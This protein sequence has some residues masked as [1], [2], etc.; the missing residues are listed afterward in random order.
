MAL[1][2][3]HS[4]AL[5]GLQAPPVTVEA[6]VGNGLPAFHLVGLPDAEVRESRERVRAAILEAGLEFPQRRLTVNLAPADLPKASG[7][8]DLPIALGLLAASGQ[9]PLARLDD[10]EFVGELSLTGSIRSIRGALAMVRALRRLQGGR[11]LVVPAGNAAEAGLVADTPACAAATLVEVVAY[12]RGERSLAACAAPAWPPIAA[13]G[14]DLRDVK[15]Q[16]AAR[17]ALEIAAAGE[18]HLLMVG[19][20]GAGKSMLAQRIGSILPPLPVDEAIEAAAVA[21]LRGPLA[22]GRWQLRPVRAP[23]HSASAAAIVGGGSPPGPGEISLAHGGVLFLDELPEFQR[24]VLEALREPLEAG[25]ISLARAGSA[26]TLPARF[27]LLA[28]MNPCPCG[29]AG[30]PRCRCRAADVQRY[31]ARISGPL[32]ERIDLH[33]RLAPVDEATLLGRADG[34]PSGA[35]AARVATARAAQQARQGVPNGRLDAAAIQ[36]HCPAEPDAAALLRTAA[37]RLGWSARVLHR[38]LRVARTVADLDGGADAPIGV[39]A[40][41]EAV[42]LRRPVLESA[43]PDHPDPGGPQAD[44]GA[45]GAIAGHPYHPDA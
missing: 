41:A 19:P 10:H 12:L 9:V 36:R 30:T 17:R 24:P 39:A 31:Q 7:R 28:A 37:Q 6:H 32:A 44:G 4:R 20:P 38:V 1:A 26:V 23:H 27:Q 3:V 13:A 22:D 14:G 33:L 15:G 43:R 29:H 11:T 18:H 16:A 25:T 35:V 45:G 5:L 42:Q 8:F 21:S 2:I 40:V 34:E